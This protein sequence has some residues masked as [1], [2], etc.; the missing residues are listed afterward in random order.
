[1]SS[2]D[3]YKLPTEEPV[4]K[5]PKKAK[6]KPAEPVEDDRPTDTWVTQCPNETE[7]DKQEPDDLNTVGCDKPFDPLGFN[8]GRFDG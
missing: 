4:F 6:P 1:M 5:A 7:W 3:V 2:D 8:K